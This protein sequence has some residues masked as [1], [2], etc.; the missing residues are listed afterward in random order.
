MTNETQTPQLTVNP[1]FDNDTGAWTA[2]LGSDDPVT[3]ENLRAFAAE[4][5]QRRVEQSKSDHATFVK[6]H[7][8]VDYEPKF[9]DV[10]EEETYFLSFLRTKKTAN[11]AIPPIMLAGQ[12]VEHL[13]HGRM[14][15]CSGGEARMAERVLATKRIEIL[16]LTP[17]RDGL[18]ATMQLIMEQWEYMTS[19]PEER[20]A[21]AAKRNRKPF[22]N[23]TEEAQALEDVAEGQIWIGDNTPD[24][25]SDDQPPSPV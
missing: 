17:R 2:S 20:K 13:K 4:Q 22:A 6:R 8:G 25:Y 21:A 7:M 16:N 9:L 12:N 15:A 1:G 23:Y 10:W 3:A 19:T 18:R 5:F 11:V 24:G 14:Y